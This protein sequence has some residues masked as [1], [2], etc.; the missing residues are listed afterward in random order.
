MNRQRAHDLHRIGI[1]YG[2]VGVLLGAPCAQAGLTGINVDAEYQVTYEASDNQAKTLPRVRIG[3]T[4]LLGAREFLIV[5]LPGSPTSWVK[6]YVDLTS[7]RSIL[8]VDA[9]EY[10]ERPPKR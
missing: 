7:V 8:P 1:V 3:D 6:G 2:L 4:V 10:S 5:E 9:L